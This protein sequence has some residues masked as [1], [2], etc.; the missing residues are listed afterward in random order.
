MDNKFS[1]STFTCQILPALLVAF[2]TEVSYSFRS[3]YLFR[4]ELLCRLLFPLIFFCSL[5]PSAI[6]MKFIV[7]FFLFA[8]CIR[9]AYK[10]HPL[11]HEN[12]FF[13]FCFSRTT[14]LFEFFASPQ[15]FTLRAP[16]R[17][18]LLLVGEKLLLRCTPANHL[19]FP[20]N[21]VFNYYAIESSLFSLNQRSRNSKRKT[22]FLIH[23]L[24]VISEHFSRDRNR[25][26]F[27]QSLVHRLT[28]VVRF[29]GGKTEGKLRKPSASLRGEKSMKTRFAL[30]NPCC[31]SV[32]MSST[33]IFSHFPSP[34][35]LEILSPPQKSFSAFGKPFRTSFN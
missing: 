25:R 20:P 32:E 35:R 2:Q 15:L 34:P 12:R 29:F 30:E 18:N 6:Q 10:N 16:V 26:L 21:S 24:H 4:F 11:Q 9:I 1:I 7:S 31:V 19:L 5:A 13:L 14:F 33:L 22:L 28:R 17:W 8:F 3:H 23:K 27:Q